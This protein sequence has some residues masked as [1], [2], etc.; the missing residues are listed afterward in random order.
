MNGAGSNNAQLNVSVDSSLLRHYSLFPR[1]ADIGGLYSSNNRNSAPV[2]GLALN[3][4]GVPTVNAP[5]PDAAGA[6]PSVAVMS[7]NGAAAPST[8]PSNGISA[9]QVPGPMTGPGV[10]VAAANP[11]AL[12]AA[13]VD[14]VMPTLTNFIATH[15]VNAGGV[16]GETVTPHAG[17]HIVRHVQLRASLPTIQVWEFNHRTYRN[18]DVFLSDIKNLAVM[19]GQDMAHLLLRHLQERLRSTA[20]LMVSEL[21]AAGKQFTWEEA[22][23]IF[24]HVAGLDLQQ[25]REQALRALIGHKVKQ[26]TGQTVIEYACIL[27]QYTTRAQITDP[28][29]Q[30]EFF[31]IGLL[32]NLQPDCMFTSEGKHWTDLQSCIVHAISVEANKK[33]AKAA[34]AALRA[35]PSRPATFQRP[36][37]SVDNRHVRFSDH[38]TPSGPPMRTS[39]NRSMSAPLMRSTD[40]HVPSA[41]AVRSHDRRGGKLRFQGGCKRRRDD[42][43]GR[44]PRDRDRDRDSYRD[45]GRRRFVR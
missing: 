18:A 11:G 33:R 43:Y 20:E 8:V 24:R 25:S 26:S 21:L 40:H 39:E 16:S 19:T 27:R 32:P 15:P 12:V 41:D 10:A 13:A 42:D 23:R 9:G 1:I 34:L 3:A 31:I 7:Q 30:C 14:S 22:V 44:G 36:S 28:S 2:D 4:N 45:G 38:S 6:G 29:Q 5:A 37:L 17:Q 35:P